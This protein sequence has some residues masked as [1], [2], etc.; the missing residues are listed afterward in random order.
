MSLD[1][2]LRSQLPPSIWHHI[3]FCYLHQPPSVQR[4]LFR[5]E[6]VHRSSNVPASSLNTPLITS[7]YHCSARIVATT[8]VYIQCMDRDAGRSVSSNSVTRTSCGLLS[9]SLSDWRRKTWIDGTYGVT[10][11]TIIGNLCRGGVQLKHLGGDPPTIHAVSDGQQYNGRQL[12]WLRDYC[13]DDVDLEYP[14]Y[15]VDDCMF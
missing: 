4:P 2:C 12:N 13:S 10:R 15:V 6:I 7:K 9:I 1:T 5:F 3:R 14:T 11:L 8:Y